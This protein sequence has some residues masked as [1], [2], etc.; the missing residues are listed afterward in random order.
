M[1]PTFEI[2]T[3]I[4]VRTYGR[5]GMVQG[6]AKHLAAKIDAQEWDSRGREYMIMRTCW[7]W[8]TGGSTADDVAKRIEAALEHPSN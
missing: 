4:L 8:M 2:V 6:L 1:I 7:D 3:P 5:G